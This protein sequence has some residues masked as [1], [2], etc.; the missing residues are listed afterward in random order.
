MS[1]TD[2]SASGNERPVVNES[3]QGVDHMLCFMSLA[4][5]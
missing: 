5:A 2:Q 1:D 4:S 3:Q